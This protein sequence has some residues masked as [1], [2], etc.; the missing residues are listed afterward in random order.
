MPL[1]GS[2]G[3]PGTVPSPEFPCLVLKMAA[4]QIG[5]QPVVK[6]LQQGRSNVLSLIRVGG[7]WFTVERVGRK[8][9]VLP[10][11]QAV[12]VPPDNGTGVVVPFPARGR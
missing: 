4:P 9:N 10:V 3:I 1:A 2:G 8:V 12:R 11:K 7:R 5:E 6:S